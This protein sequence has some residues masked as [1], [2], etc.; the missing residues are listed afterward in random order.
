MGRKK[1]TVISRDG[2]RPE[3][4]GDYFMGEGGVVR[5]KGDNVGCSPIRINDA[6]NTFSQRHSQ[7]T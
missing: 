6:S 1:L 3:L 2:S 7:A 5:E 4:R